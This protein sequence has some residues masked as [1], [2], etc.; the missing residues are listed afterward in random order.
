MA[1]LALSFGFFLFVTVLGRA[2]LAACR[3]PGGILRSW[4]LAPACGLSVVVLGI[5]LLNQAG[6]PVRTFAW[7]LTLALAAT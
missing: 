6:L 2:T 7:P 1:A 5:M 3:W 4:L